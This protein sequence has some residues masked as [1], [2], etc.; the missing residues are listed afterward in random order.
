MTLIELSF[1]ANIPQTVEWNY[2][3]AIVMIAAN[4]VAVFIGRFAIQNAGVGPDLPVGKPALWKNFGL[5]ELLAT[6]S[7]GHILGAGFILG[8]SNAGLL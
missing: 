8:L 6:L 2:N 1:L 5:P 3:V 4:L 7:F